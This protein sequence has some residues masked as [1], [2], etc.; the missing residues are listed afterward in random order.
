MARFAFAEVVRHS[1][2][3]AEVLGVMNR[4]LQ[5]LTDER[6][7]TAFYGVLD[8]K[9]R[10]FC[11]ANA[12][13][14]PALRVNPKHGEVEQLTSR[15]LMLG[16]VPNAVYD[17][18]SLTLEPGDRLCFYT[19]GVVDSR[20]VSKETFGLERLVGHGQRAGLLEV[21]LDRVGAGE[22][23]Q[24]AQVGEPLGLEP[25]ELV[26]K[27]AD[28]VGQAVGQRRLAEAA[29]PA[30]RPERDGLSL[31]DDHPQARIRVGQGERRPQAGE[32]TPDDEDVAGAVFDRRE[33]HRRGVATEPEGGRHAT[34]VTPLHAA[35]RVPSTLGYVVIR[36]TS[37][38]SRRESR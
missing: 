10:E 31:E 18:K 37:D 27:V 35:H 32:A 29:V 7:V 1:I 4:R 25:L 11:Y 13:H 30:G 28:P 22:G 20:N 14:P 16:I 26:R 19:D 24:L 6:F 36:T 23:D 34:M 5:G 21:A 2:R 9:T 12:G 33:I 8:R 38:A 3:P 15:G 17:E